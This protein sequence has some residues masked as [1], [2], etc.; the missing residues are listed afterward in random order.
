M[1]AQVF[2]FLV[3]LRITRHHHASFAY[4]KVL[5]GEKAPGR[6]IAESAEFAAFV[7]A[8]IRMRAIFDELKV[9][10]LTDIDNRIHIASIACIVHN[11]YRL[12]ARCDLGLDIGRIHGPIGQ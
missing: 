1:R 6:Y 3:E 8:A 7:R 2:T 5:V 10:S 9:V 11:H 12:G 4:R